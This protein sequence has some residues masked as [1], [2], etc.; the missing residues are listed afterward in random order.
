MSAIPA[1][2]TVRLRTTNGGD[3]GVKLLTDWSPGDPGT[4]QY[5][6]GSVFT[7]E[8]WRIKSVTVEPV[9]FS[10]RYDP[11]YTSIYH[12]WTPVVLLANDGP[13]DDGWFDVARYESGYESG[14]PWSIFQNEIRDGLVEVSFL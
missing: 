5:P 1:G 9:T 13:E 7:V 14:D 2:T 11:S 4:F 8:W 6:W 3:T 12:E 10:V